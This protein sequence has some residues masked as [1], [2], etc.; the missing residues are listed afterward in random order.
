MNT[1]EIQKVG[2]K[3]STYAVELKT[4]FFFHWSILSGTTLTLIIPLLLEMQKQ[5]ILCEVLSIKISILLLII[6]IIF[7]SIKN[8]LSSYSLWNSGLAN[9]EESAIDNNKFNKLA[10]KVKTINYKQKILEP[11]PLIGYVF[12][13]IFLYVFMLNNIF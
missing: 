5:N 8:Y 3:Q 4:K 9:L 1:E 11:I 6:S 10:K 12:A 7:S 2:L 13:L